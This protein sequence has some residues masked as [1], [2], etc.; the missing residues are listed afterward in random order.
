MASDS[1]SQEKSEESSEK[2]H[3]DHSSSDPAATTASGQTKVTSNPTQRSLI[4]KPSMQSQFSVFLPYPYMACLDQGRAWV[5][6]DYGTLQLVDRDGTV[7]DTMR[8]DFDPNDMIV[9]ADGDLLMVDYDS[10]CIKSVSKQKTFN[11]LFTMSGEPFGLC[12]LHNGE[13]VVTFCYDS[14]VIVYGKDG[15]I[16]RTLDNIKFRCPTSVAVNKVNHDIYVCDHVSSNCR[17]RGKLV[18]VEAD[19]QLRYE[20]TGKGS[21]PFAPVDVCTDEMGLVLITDHDNKRVHI[22]DQEGQFIQYVLTSQQGLDC[23]TTIAVDR[24]GYVWVGEVGGH[25]KVA[26]YLQ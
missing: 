26:R 24:E 3:S 11:T 4:P 25:V 12:C 1:M 2:S 18:T 21:K 20:Y 22:L 5:Y 19:G 7:R 13:I 15:K 14:T 10:K 6:T 8:T 17:S 16:I 23:P 9:T